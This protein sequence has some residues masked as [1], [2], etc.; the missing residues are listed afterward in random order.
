M[1]GRPTP[2]STPLAPKTIAQLESNTVTE[3][4]TR[5]YKGEPNMGSIGLPATSQLDPRTG[6]RLSEEYGGDLDTVLMAAD[7]MRPGGPLQSRGKIIL[8][9]R[10]VRADDICCANPEMQ[11]INDLVLGKV[12][13]KASLHFTRDEAVVTVHLRHATIPATHLNMTRS[14]S[15][16]PA[17]EICGT[18]SSHLALSASV[19]APLQKRVLAPTTIPQPK[20]DTEIEHTSTTNQETV[21]KSLKPYHNSTHELQMDIYLQTPTGEYVPGHEV[22]WELNPYA[23]VCGDTSGL[24]GIVPGHNH[25]WASTTATTLCTLVQ[26]DLRSQFYKTPPTRESSPTL[27]PLWSLGKA[28]VIN[29]QKR[30]TSRRQAL[31]AREY[32]MNVATNPLVTT[33]SSTLSPNQGRPTTDDDIHQEA[34]AQ[35]PINKEIAVPMK[36]NNLFYKNGN[37][38]TPSTGRLLI[39]GLTSR[40]RKRPGGRKKDRRRDRRRGFP[41]EVLKELNSETAERTNKVDD[42]IQTLNPA[43]DRMLLFS[44]IKY[45]VGIK[46]RETHTGVIHK[47]NH[48]GDASSESP[49]Q[50]KA[51][52]PR[53]HPVEPATGIGAAC[54]EPN[55][56]LLLQDPLNHDTYD[57]GKTLSRSIGSLKHRDS[58]LAEKHG[59]D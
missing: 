26:T 6:Q 38:K 18:Y 46:N 51:T 4:V 48:F 5:E 1:S 22:H 30:F 52:L 34:T 20:T 35:E 55:T 28:K 24:M 59:P 54:F 8:G 44:F 10:P 53:E 9:D 57:P 50:Y 2:Q 45:A 56:A 25:L 42:P 16:P 14:P 29:S 15:Q 13:S 31:E 40:E 17:L 43:R 47:T 58:V 23:M 27:Q 41:A 37:P 3:R 11:A 32:A 33:S 49:T 7:T 21:E 36:D 12:G 39:R 19:L